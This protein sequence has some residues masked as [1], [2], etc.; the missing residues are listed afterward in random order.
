VNGKGGS[1]LLQRFAAFDLVS[2]FR[3]TGATSRSALER[4]IKATTQQRYHDHGPLQKTATRQ[5]P[6][7]RCR[8]SGVPSSTV[9]EV[10]VSGN[11]ASGS[12]IQSCPPITT[13][14]FPCPSSSSD[15]EVVDDG[16][17]HGC[18]GASCACV[19]AVEISPSFCALSFLSPSTTIDEPC[20]VSSGKKGEAVL[21]IRRRR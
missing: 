9:F 20:T 4:M 13:K 10:L 11:V 21:V 17:E 15:D 5:A 2:H 8:H 16:E 14:L 6:L 19:L 18:V 7:G 1:S 12:D 3:Q